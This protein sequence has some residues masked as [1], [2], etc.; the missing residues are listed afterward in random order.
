VAISLPCSWPPSLGVKTAARNQAQDSSEHNVRDSISVERKPL[1]GVRGAAHAP[2]SPPF[3]GDHKGVKERA[4]YAEAPEYRLNPTRHTTRETTS[5]SAASAT[6]A[7]AVS[8]SSR[9]V[10][11]SAGTVTANATGTISV[12]PKRNHPG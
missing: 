5:N 3:R 12:S 4:R 7:I 6:A 11:A 10:S 8:Q 1:Q 9:P 2:R